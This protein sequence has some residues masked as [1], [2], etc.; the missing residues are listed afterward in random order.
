MSSERTRTSLEEV[1]EAWRLL[2]AAGDPPPDEIVS[3]SSPWTF[4]GD[5][6]ALARDGKG[7]RHLLVPINTHDAFSPDKAS[8]GVQMTDQVLLEGG[9]RKRYID[10]VCRKEHLKS[11]FSVLITEI[12]EALKV[13]GRPD[14]AIHSV[15]ERWR[16]LLSREA[17]S[18]PS[19]EALVGAFAELLVLAELCDGAPEAARAWV[20]P[21]GER[22]DI[23][24][25]AGS[26]EVKGTR[27]RRGRQVE[28]HGVEQLE[29]P[30]QGD[31]FLAYVRL[32]AD[33]G[34]R[35]VLDL[36]E[37]LESQGCP[38]DALRAGLVKLGIL[39][40][41]H[42]QV[43]GR[44]FSVRER[45]TYLV[46]AAFPRITRA[47][48]SGG[49]LPG[50]ILSLTYA[51]DLSSEPPEPRADEVWRGDLRRLRESMR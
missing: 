10:V 13:P 26:V 36:V 24:T 20:G 49:A 2:E 22:H 16:E 27:G 7:H 51:L 39:P 23:V 47:S 33:P 8:A 18:G 21:D 11:H 42:E 1:E 34:G 28:I 6:M 31:L 32:E 45:N 41:H 19:L 37:E 38:S 40:E 35:S 46:D 25:P 15:L 5:P 14:Q 29:A 44:G 9:R 50:G 4:R 30:N 48:F 17:T 3:R 12:L 43:R